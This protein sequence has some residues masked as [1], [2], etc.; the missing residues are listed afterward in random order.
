[1]LVIAAHT[2]NTMQ[3]GHLP[4]L[5]TSR[6]PASRPSGCPLLRTAAASPPQPSR[7]NA[8]QPHRPPRSSGWKHKQP[9]RVGPQRHKRRQ[10]ACELTSDQRSRDSRTPCSCSSPSASLCWRSPQPSNSHPHTGATH[11]TQGPAPCQ[12]HTCTYLSRDVYMGARAV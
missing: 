5:P 4:F 3:A 2:K 1:M 6:W 10:V 11:T 8:Q 7:S 12:I 9:V